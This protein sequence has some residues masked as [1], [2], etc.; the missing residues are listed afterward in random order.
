M[1]FD[2]THEE[3]RL[4][5]S[6]RTVITRGPH[7]RIEG[8]LP[9]VQR[10]HVHNP[11][12]FADFVRN[13]GTSL[14]TEAYTVAARGLPE[15]D[16]HQW[17]LRWEAFDGDDQAG[18]RWMASQPTGDDV[19][20]VFE[21]LNSPADRNNPATAI[22]TLRTDCLVDIQRVVEAAAPS[23]HR[24]ALTPDEELDY[25][26]GPRLG[27][28]VDTTGAVTAHAA[29]REQDPFEQCRLEVLLAMVGSGPGVMTCDVCGRWFVPLRGG[30]PSRRCPGFECPQ[31]AEQAY[32]QSDDRREYR[33]LQMRLSRAQRRGDTAAAAE[34][35]AAMDAL[36]RPTTTR[37]KS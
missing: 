9:L 5:V 32:Q 35:Q 21:V 17:H 26:T 1:S 2:Y 20:R 25:L 15:R 30:R 33:R 10:L 18:E 19:R 16:Q 22:E 37:G 24:P 36:R 12:P 6:V 31:I 7:R 23:S 4:S 14:V 11:V 28:R 27:W 8:L 3:R 29:T 34:A 13:Y